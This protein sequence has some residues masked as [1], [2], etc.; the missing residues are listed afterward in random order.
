[1][2]HVVINVAIYMAVVAVYEILPRYTGRPWG[3]YSA[4]ILAW[5]ATLLMVLTV[6]PHHLLM[7]FAMPDWMAFWGQ[8]IS[9]A[10]ALPVFAVTLVGTLANVHRSGMRWDLTSGL[11]MLSI[12]GWSAGVVPAVLDGTIAIN[13]VMHNTQ[14]VPGHFH[15]YLLL[16]VVPMLLAFMTWIGNQ[17]RAGQFGGLRG[18]AFW[19]YGVTGLGFT[20]AF[21]FAGAAG[22]P[23]RYAVHL[24]QW[25]GYDRV[26]SVFALLVLLAAAAIILP[27]VVRIASRGRTVTAA[28]R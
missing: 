21:L 13:Q 1:F 27:A 17:G 12:F 19:L 16:G 23:R 4:F 28:A 6:Y 2:G 24:V 8:I 10:S 25:V 14:W 22:V 9:Y 5:N 20:M 7:D 18:G 3:V 26:A 11:L 15:T